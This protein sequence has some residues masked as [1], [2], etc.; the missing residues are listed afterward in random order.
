MDEEK[1][2]QKKTKKT[3]GQKAENSPVERKSLAGNALSCV[4]RSPD[5][6]VWSVYIIVTARW[7]CHL[8]LETL[9]EQLNQWHFA[10]S[11]ESGVGVVG[12]DSRF[13]AGDIQV[14]VTRSISHMITVYWYQRKKNL[15]EMGLVK[16]GV[17]YLIFHLLFSKHS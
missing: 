14:A 6:L 12:R 11:L 5:G 7:L 17:Y 9:S 16:L 1:E 8:K 4:S 15:L 13:I 2:K 3:R 10:Y